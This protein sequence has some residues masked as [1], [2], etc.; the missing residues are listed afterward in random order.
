MAT[1][2]KSALSNVA[3]IKSVDLVSFEPDLVAR[4][5]LLGFVRPGLNQVQVDVYFAR[6]D[7]LHEDGAPRHN[8]L[9][10]VVAC[11]A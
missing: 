1:W 11:S 6:T 7:D 10:E 4:T 8:E 5:A 9:G 3:P 2:P